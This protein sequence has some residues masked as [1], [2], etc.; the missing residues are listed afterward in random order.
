MQRQIGNRKVLEGG[1][2][3]A[4]QYQN[5]YLLIQKPSPWPDPQENLP[6]EPLAR[7]CVHCIG[8][9]PNKSQ[10]QFYS[11]FQRRQKHS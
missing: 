7:K 6:A 3:K 4:L 9:K 10:R 5:A 1:G 2:S 11:L 8:W